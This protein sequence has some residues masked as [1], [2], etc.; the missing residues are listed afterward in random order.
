MRFAWKMGG[1]VERPIY[2][3]SF[4]PYLRY[5]LVPGEKFSYTSINSDGFRGGEYTIAK[6]NNTFRIIML[7]DSETL[8]VKLADKDTLPYQLE[9]ILNENS[10]DIDYQVFNFGVEGYCTFQELEMLKTKGLKYDPDL[11]ILNYVLNDPEPGEYYFEKNFLIRHSALVRYFTF[12]IKKRLIKRERK[13]LNINTEIDNYYY[14]HQAKYFDRVR[15]ALREM[16]EIARDF[17]NKLLV[18]IFPTSSIMVKDFRAGYPYLPLHELVKGLNSKDIVTINLLD[19]FNRLDLSPQAVSID[20]H[21]DESHK[22]P[23][24]LRVAAEYIYRRLKNEKMIPQ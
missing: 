7:G 8:S 14:Y 11:I 22:N 21:N 12:R 5:E 2:Q 9:A 4:N 23:Q 15:D 18:V 24:A 1:W 3:R 17:D 13:K 10:P 16:S 6:T 19:E 20:Y